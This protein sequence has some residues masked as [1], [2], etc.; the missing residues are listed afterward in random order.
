MA[1]LTSRCPT[2]IGPLRF[3]LLHRRERTPWFE[4][5]EGGKIRATTSSWEGAI[6]PLGL[7]HP[8]IEVAE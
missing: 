4:R 1:A 2:A 6:W 8:F 7:D 5:I 3:R